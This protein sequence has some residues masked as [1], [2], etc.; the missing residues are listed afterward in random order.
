MVVDDTDHVRRMLSSMLALDGFEVVA[1]VAGGAEAVE[2]VDQVDPDIIVMDYRMPGIDG[3]EAARA[4]RARRP[5]QIV[6]LYTAFVDEELE[7][8]AADAGVS[9]C[10]GKVEGLPSLEREIRR[11]CASLF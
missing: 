2:S 1:G 11:L 7:R 9:L 8:Q 4:V 6:V 3:L 5:D 10:I